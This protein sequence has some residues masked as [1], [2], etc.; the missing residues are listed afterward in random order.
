[1]SAVANPK[2]DF[3]LAFLG[4][5]PKLPMDYLVYLMQRVS[6]TRER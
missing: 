2:R 1:M 4:C 3:L 5:G 6:V